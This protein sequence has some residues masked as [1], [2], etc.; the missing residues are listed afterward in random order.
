MDSITP[1]LGSDINNGI[2]FAPSLGIED[3]VTANQPQSKGIHQRAL[4]V[5]GLQLGLAAQVGHTK[6]VAVRGDAAAYPFEHRVVAVDSALIC[7]LSGSQRP[8]PQAVQ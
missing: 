6:T 3:L 4:R 7:A 5:T 8:E 1:R 2:A